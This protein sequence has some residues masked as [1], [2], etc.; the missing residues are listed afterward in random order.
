MADPNYIIRIQNI[1]ERN[2]L[3]R[4][5][6]KP[7]IFS[8]N[9]IID[10]MLQNKIPTQMQHCILKVFPKMQG[11]EH[12]KFVSAS[13]ICAAVFQRYGYM[14]PGSTVLTGKG[15]RN[16]TRHRLELDAGAKRSNYEALKNR[17][18]R[19]YLDRRD[20]TLKQKKRNESAIASPSSNIAKQP[21]QLT[22][23]ILPGTPSTNII[24]AKGVTT[25]TRKMPTED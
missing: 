24:K 16:N 10:L 23:A 7:L 8:E 19:G 2:I 15:M 17:L 13:N 11:T 14:Q 12:E 1:R 3:S 4:T 22:K 9:Q 25:S 20:R 21:Q 18:W 6:G 5:K